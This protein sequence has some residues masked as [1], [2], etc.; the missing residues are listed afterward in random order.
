[1]IGWGKIEAIITKNPLHS[2]NAVQRKKWIAYNQFLAFCDI[3]EL[4]IAFHIENEPHQS[5]CIQV[6]NI[7]CA[8]CLVSVCI[9]IL[10]IGQLNQFCKI[11]VQ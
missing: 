10:N 5:S 9:C 2:G 3:W 7:I 8:V 11:F 4:L 6:A 1:M